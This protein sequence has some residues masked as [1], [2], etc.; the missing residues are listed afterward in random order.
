MLTAERRQ[1]ILRVL[2]QDGKVVAKRVSEE[3]GTSEDTIRRDL[4]ELAAEGA[5]QRVHG[6]A[7]PRPPVY[8]NFTSRQTQ[9]PARKATIARAAIQFVRNGQVILLDGGTTNIQVAQYLPQDLHATVV[10]NN[11][12]VAIALEAHHPHIEIVL[13]GGNIL[14]E[15][16]VTLGTAT[17]ETIR[18]MRADIYFLGV[19]GL[20]PSVGISTNHLEEAYLKRAMIACA[21]E[22]IALTVPEKL[23]TASPYIVGQLSELTAIITE[24][25]VLDEV[26]EPYRALDI[27]V[28]KAL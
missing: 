16:M 25:S 5:L 7:L 2:S 17:L 28:V 20:H 9:A 23:N 10:T 27:T 14:K 12:H 3:L 13:L 24:Q 18:M 22:V 11:P 1:Y 15:A 26:L 6:G 4:R 21:S 19:C 8:G